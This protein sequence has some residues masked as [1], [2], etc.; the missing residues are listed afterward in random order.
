MSEPVF[1]RPES[2]LVVVY[3]EARQ[4]LLIQRADLPDFWQSVTGTL[5]RGELPAAA[6]RRELAE[7][8]GLELQLVD[9]RQHRNRYR[10]HPHWAHR[11]APAVTHNVEHVFT[12]CL[13]APRPIVLNPAEHLSFDWYPLDLALER[14]SSTSNREAITQFVAPAD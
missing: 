3:T 12:V 5:E 6:A 4:V 7:E 14:C 1:R 2:V 9:D 13:P 8:T 10:I 11:Y